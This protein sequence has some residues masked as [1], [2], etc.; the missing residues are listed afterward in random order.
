[1]PFTP[2]TRAELSEIALGAIVARSGL[3]DTAQGS[4]I[5][6]LAQSMAA[7]AASSERK[8]GQVRAAFDLRN[9]T[10]AELDERLGELPPYS[11]TR[12]GA[13][14]A[15]G[16]VR[17]TFE[18]LSSSQTIPAG[19]SFGSSTNQ[20]LVYLT[21]E[22][23]TLNTGA[24]SAEIAVESAQAGSAGNAGAGTIDTILS[25]PAFI[26]AATNEAPISGGL[27]EETDSALKR[28]ALLYLTSLARSQPRALEHL[29]YTQQTAAGRV[30]LAALFESP[31]Q[32]GY[33]ELYIDDGTGQLD[34]RTAAGPIYQGT[35]GPS[36]VSVVYFQ[37]PA[38]SAPVLLT[39]ESGSFAPLDPA[40]YVAIPERGALYIEPAIP[41]GVSYKLGSYRY[42]SGLIEAL[43]LEIEGDTS[44]PSAAQGWRAAGT[45][46]RVLPAAPYVLSFDLALTVATGYDLDS[47]AAAAEQAIIELTFELTIGAPLYV[48]RLLCAIMETEGATNA[49]LYRAGTGTEPEPEPLAD[50]YPPRDRVIRLGQVQIVP[51]AE[52]S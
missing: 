1:M 49:H 28:R 32:A 40:R 18:A 2:R 9:A 12:H 50:I 41:E 34:S 3:D 39:D 35:A 38:V 25:A 27:D 24:T 45:R 8:I 11:I 15:R 31:D 16:L 22:A 4:V 10:G 43:Q 19:S 47:V 52:E 13:V 23:L 30:I 21:T 6:T 17:L 29:A 26:V 36:G 37:S 44:N 20:A 14:N 51:A 42:F 7:L 5:D 33:S 46:V 48:S